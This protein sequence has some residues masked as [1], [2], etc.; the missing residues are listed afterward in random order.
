MGISGSFRGDSRRL[1]DVKGFLR[2]F[3]G[4][5]GGY[6][7]DACAFQRLPLGLS[8]GSRGLA[9]PLSA[10]GALEGVLW[11]LHGVPGSST[12]L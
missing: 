9:L 6:S 10:S 1:R 11:S 2:H 12:E 7:E 3:K 8:G 4:S 5:Q